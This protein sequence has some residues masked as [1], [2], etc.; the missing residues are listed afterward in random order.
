MVLGYIRKG[1]PESE[2][3]SEPGGKRARSILPWFLLQVSAQALALT[4]FTDDL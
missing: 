1:D 3:E 4:S 2:T